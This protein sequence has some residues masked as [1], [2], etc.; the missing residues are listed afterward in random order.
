[1]TETGMSEVSECILQQVQDALDGDW[2]PAREVWQRIG[3]WA[4]QTIRH[5]LS[6]LARKGRCERRVEEIPS[7]TIHKFRRAP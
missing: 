5:A 4:P 2:R 7:G 6:V 3:C 1:M